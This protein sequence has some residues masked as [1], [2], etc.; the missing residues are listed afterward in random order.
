MVTGGVTELI[1]KCKCFHSTR[2]TTSFRDR[3]FQPTVLGS[4]A[5]QTGRTAGIE[6]EPVKAVQEEPKSDEKVY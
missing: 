2:H 6:C 1:N 3:V 5:H 4:T